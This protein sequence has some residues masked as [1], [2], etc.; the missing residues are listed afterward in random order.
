MYLNSG[1]TSSSLGFTFCFKEI[2]KSSISLIFQAILKSSSSYTNSHIEAP[3]NKRT[4]I[5]FQ[6]EAAVQVS[7]LYNVQLLSYSIYKN[8]PTY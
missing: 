1:D 5:L 4:K 6:R 8:A 3:Q 7:C 2:I